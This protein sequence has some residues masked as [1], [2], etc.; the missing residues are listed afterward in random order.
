MR[1]VCLMALFFAAPGVGWAQQQE[2]AA[3]QPRCWLGSMSYSPG[4]TVR[5]GDNVMLCTPAF[6]WE[7]ATKS[8]A[9]GCIF[10]SEFYNSGAV[11]SGNECQPDGT[12]TTVSPAKP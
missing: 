9:S 4:A 12:W 2:M 11:V 5:A 7:P 3:P 8:A 1:P 6:A 10:K